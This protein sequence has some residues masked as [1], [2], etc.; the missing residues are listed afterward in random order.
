MF[1]TAVWGAEQSFKHLEGVVAT[2]VG[3]TDSPA[4]TEIPTYESVCAGS[5][6]AEAVLVAYDPSVLAYE[7]CAILVLKCFTYS[8]VAGMNTNVDRN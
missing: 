8:N 5:G 1:L 2:C 4:S 3:Y 6:H 7:V